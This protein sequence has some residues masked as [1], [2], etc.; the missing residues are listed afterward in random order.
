MRKVVLAFAIG[1]AWVSQSFGQ[2]ELAFKAPQPGTESRTQVETEIKQTLT[3]A[4]MP[5]ETH[6]TQF[7]VQ[8]ESIREAGGALESV[9]SFDTMS[10]NL[11]L[12]G[13]LNYSFDSGNPDAPV[14]VPMLQSLSDLLKQLVKSEM[15]TVLTPDGHAKEVHWPDGAFA[16][17]PDA[18]KS[19]IDPEM[20]KKAWN[21]IVDQLPGKLVNPGDSWTRME[22]I[23]LGAGQMMYFEQK[24]TYQGPATE[25]GKPMHKISVETESVRLTMEPNAT[26]PLSLKKSDLKIK[27]S[28]GTLTYDPAIGALRATDTMVQIV[29]ALTL[30]LNGM[31]L[32]SELDL[33]MAFKTTLQ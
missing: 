15:T 2:A 13:G 25:N 9:R 26:Q 17:I 22:E 11:S 10:M 4:G 19:E 23:N 18:F 3:L 29:G 20:Q 27:E 8:K 32:P 7:I 30:E 33:T 24:Y 1:L 21:Q 5:I 6:V 31:E 12:P 14:A 16:N 28:K